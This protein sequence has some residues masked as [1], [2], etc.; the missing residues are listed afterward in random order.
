MKK[1]K[2][3][4][5]ETLSREVEVNADSE[6]EAIQ[7]VSDDYRAEKYVLSSEDYM[8]TDFSAEEIAR[9][10]SHKNRDDR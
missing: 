4:I 2:I 3:T 7:K 1:Y 5:T 10:K 9:T 8:D 6:Q